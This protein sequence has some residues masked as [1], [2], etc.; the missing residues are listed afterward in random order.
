MLKLF[1]VA[2]LT[3]SLYRSL[4]AGLAMFAAVPIL[5]GRFPSPRWMVL[6]VALHAPMVALFISSMSLGTAASGI[7]LQYTA[8][9]WVALL[10]WMLQGRRVGRRTLTAMIVAG[11]GIT[12]MIA[13]GHVGGWLA[14]ILGVGSGMCY[15]GLILVLEKIDHEAG[16]RVNPAW[17]VLINNLGSALVLLPVVWHFHE[18]HVSRITFAA[19]ATTGVV[20]MAMPYILF[21]FALRKV[22]PVDASLLT[23]LEPVLNPAWVAIMTSEVPEWG[24]VVGGIAILVAMAIEAT[25]PP[26]TDT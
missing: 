9:V 18:L 7:L 1:P 24:T 5:G 25:K 6:S 11:A 14:P 15:A 12:V 26:E 16:G 10:G 13:T 19:V 2:P 22:T 23:L 3:F 4:A 21:Q 17:V 20:Q 8:P